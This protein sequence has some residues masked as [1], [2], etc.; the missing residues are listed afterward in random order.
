MITRRSALLALA[1]QLLHCWYHSYQGR[2][3]IQNYERQVWVSQFLKAILG[4]FSG[5]CSGQW[6]LPHRGPA[7]A[8]D[9]ALSPDLK[10]EV[11]RVAPRPAIVT[12]LPKE[13][14]QSRCAAAE[15]RRM[16]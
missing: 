11:L 2:Q 15:V 1:C 8:T 5:T 14:T 6:I 16:L 7:R 4:P 10:R 9:Q 3:I 12:L 13:G